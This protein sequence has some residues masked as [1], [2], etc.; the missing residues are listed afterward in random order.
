MHQPHFLI[1]DFSNLAH[2]KWQITNDSVMGGCSD[3]GFQINADG[4]AVFLGKVSLENNGG[5]ASVKNHEPLNL[6]GYRTIR[7]N[8]KGDG[9]R[10]S[11]RLQTGIEGRTDPWDYEY[12]FETNNGEWETVELPL[13]EFDAVFR[14]RPVPD[15][16]PLNASLIIRYGFL[17]SDRQEGPFRLEID[18][19]E[20]V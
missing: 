13:R 3:S 11:F 14:G 19:I 20:A 7:I 4:H 5:F 18:K 15:A 2:Q 17:I 10:Y 12:R 1:T 16:P 8:V 9:N 6:T